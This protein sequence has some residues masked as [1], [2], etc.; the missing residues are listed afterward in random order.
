[1][2]A[3]RSFLVLLLL[4]TAVLLFILFSRRATR[5]DFGPDL[6]L[7]PGPDA[8]GY[9][10]GGGAGFAYID[11]THDT[12]LYADD[13][14][15][16]L[17]LPFSFTFYGRTYTT[18]FASSNGTIHW[19]DAASQFSNDCLI[20]GPAAG[21]GEMI[22]PY[23]DDLD[24]RFE[25]FLEVETVGVAPSRIFVIEWDDVPR[26][27]D[28]DDDRVTFAVQL[29]EGSSDILFLYEDVATFEGH[30]G[31]GATIGLQSEAQD[32]TLQFS[33]DQAAVADAGRITFSHPVTPNEITEP[34]ETAAVAI[35]DQA[36]AKGP[37]AELLAALNQEGLPALT[38]LHS[39][40]R[41]GSPPRAAAW[42]QTNVIG[43]GRSELILLW[44]GGP[45]RPELA[46]LVAL[47]ADETGT[48]S[49][50]LDQSLSTRSHPVARAAIV[51]TADLTRDGRPDV[52]LQD[53][54]GQL[55]ALTTVGETLALLTIPET[56]Q[57]GLTLLDNGDGR[58]SIVRDGCQ[59]DGRVSVHWDGER[60]SVN[61][62]Q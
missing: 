16:R 11:A 10:C 55:L 33:C 51:E 1:M 42:E 62:E 31:S 54:A 28:R 25:G 34:T 47:T 40:W 50:L 27:G 35:S 21:M 12:Q 20:E 30:N 24:L 22:A 19:D 29:F 17:E 48:W 8:Y 4:V 56:C 37:T 18:L 60:F 46:Q 23:W 49:L 41:A 3:R 58:V 38:R 13:S 53:D 5:A 7:C 61:S 45:E 14:A 9:T 44:Y 59:T 26:Y 39:Q 15:A 43:D 32:W 2:R 6:A 57:G 52:L 36:A